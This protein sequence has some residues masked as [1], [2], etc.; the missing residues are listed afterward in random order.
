MVKHRIVRVRTTLDQ[1]ALLSNRGGCCGILPSIFSQPTA[2]NKTICLMLRSWEKGSETVQEVFWDW[3]GD[4]PWR[5]GKEAGLGGADLWCTPNRSLQI[6]RKPW[7]LDGLLEFAL[8]WGK[9]IRHLS[10]EGKVCSF[11]PGWDPN[12]G[13]NDPLR[14]WAIRRMNSG[15]LQRPHSIQ[16]GKRVPSSWRGHLGCTT[17]HPALSFT[18]G[19]NRFQPFHRFSFSKLMGL[20]ITTLLQRI[21]K[22]TTQIS[23]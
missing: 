6:P 5:K 23:P 21:D 1:N 17:Q 14:Q 18:G 13:Q 7:G 10:S 19:A 20:S 22:T 8:N 9:G 15:S 11:P 2:D 4:Q 3:S 12:L 16:P